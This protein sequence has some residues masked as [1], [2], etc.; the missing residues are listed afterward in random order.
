MVSAIPS[1]LFIPVSNG[2]TSVDLVSS[3]VIEEVSLLGRL[4]VF[5]LDARS[6]ITDPLKRSTRKSLIQVT[7]IRPEEVQSIG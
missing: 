6:F 4:G 7:Y 1:F 3:D 5:T 2:H